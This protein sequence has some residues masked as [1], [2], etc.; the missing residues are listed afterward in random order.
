MAEIM[1]TG[2][3]LDNVKTERGEILLTRVKAGA[4]IHGEYIANIFN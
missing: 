2:R 3:D 1:N 4:K